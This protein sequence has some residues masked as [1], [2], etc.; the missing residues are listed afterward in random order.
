MLL[1]PS[2]LPPWLL[3]VLLLLSPLL[4]LYAV[5]TNFSTTREHSDD[6][7]KLDPRML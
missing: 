1:L 5:E 7:H 3:L 4:L 6:L 2:R